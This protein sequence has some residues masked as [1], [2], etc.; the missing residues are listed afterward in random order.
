[1]DNQNEAIKTGILVRP[2][3]EEDNGTV[4]IIAGTIQQNGPHAGGQQDEEEANSKLLKMY[5]IS[6]EVTFN[7]FQHIGPKKALPT[8]DQRINYLVNVSI[9]PCLICFLAFT[10]S[11]IWR[12]FKEPPPVFEG[13]D[14]TCSKFGW[15]N[16]A[17]I[18]M[19]CNN[20]PLD[21]HATLAFLWLTLYT[22]QTMFQ[23][24]GMK[25]AHRV[26]G[27]FGF[28]LAILN[29]FG[30]VLLATYDIF[31]PMETER[32]PEFTWFM[33][34]TAAIILYCIIRSLLYVNFVPNLITSKKYPRD[35]EKHALW[36]CR[37]FLMSFTTP[38]IRFYPLILR[39]IFS[40]ECI[41]KEESLT[42]W[43]LGSMIV[44]STLTL[45]IFW[46]VNRNLMENKEPVDWFFMGFV[47]FEVMAII[48]YMLQSFRD[49][50]FIVHMA[51]C[52]E[53]GEAGKTFLNSLPIHPLLT[54]A[55][56]V[57]LFVWLFIILVKPGGM[58]AEDNDVNFRE[59]DKGAIHERTNL[60]NE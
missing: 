15:L 28:I 40:T 49:G 18:R 3:D 4:S 5:N 7:I 58:V 45:V 50:I 27:K 30:M 54:L 48:I 25:K 37:A 2:K 43:V 42:T 17:S 41:K 53:R 24:F 11:V 23:K 31:Y 52:W 6:K 12:F 36:M 35:V 57:G 39:Y 34:M 16:N 33:F 9:M 22:V 10:R 60:I 38:V 19:T 29:V 47:G 26:V 14:M 32:P 1:M 13:V 21:I 55:L 8:K 44:A 56:T 59:S 51:E 20:R 46:L